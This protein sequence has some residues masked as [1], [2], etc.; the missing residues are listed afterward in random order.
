M[1]RYNTWILYYIVIDIFYINLMAAV[2]ENAVIMEYVC[3]NLLV[4]LLLPYI[5]INY[6]PL[7]KQRQMTLYINY[8]CLHKIMI[9]GYKCVWLSNG[10]IA[11]SRLKWTCINTLRPRQNGRHFADDISKCNFYVWISTK[12]S[13]TFV[14]KGPINNI[15]ALVQIMAWRRPGDKPLSEPMMVSLLTHLCVTR[16]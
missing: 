8:S 9:V 15:P 13:L 10:S 12:I 1:T 2:I 6:T 3:V 5:T 16:L 14:L 11:A 7:W 4:L